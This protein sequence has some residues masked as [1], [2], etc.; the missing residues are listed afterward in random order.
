MYLVTS[1][2]IKL[3]IIKH[4]SAIDDS[5]VRIISFVRIS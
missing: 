2:M 3:I 1:Y 5:D 4:T